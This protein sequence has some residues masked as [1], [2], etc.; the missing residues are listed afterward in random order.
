MRIE[1]VKILLENGANPLVK[2]DL[3]L[4]ALEICEKFGPYPKITALLQNYL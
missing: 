3:G 2:N 1:I 4:N